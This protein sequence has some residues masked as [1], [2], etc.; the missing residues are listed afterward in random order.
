MRLEFGS[1]PVSS[2]TVWSLVQRLGRLQQASLKPS[3][4][5]HLN[6]MV[7]VISQVAKM[8]PSKGDPLRIGALCILFLAS[9]SSKTRGNPNPDSSGSFSE[10]KLAQRW[11]CLMGEPSAPFGF[12]SNSPNQGTL[13]KTQLDSNNQRPTHLPFV[14]LGFRSRRPKWS[15]R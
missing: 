15:P 1:F 2:F 8:H 4:G 9:A 10:C 14:S 5:A 7:K 6:Q 11:V 13:K 12:P 3:Q